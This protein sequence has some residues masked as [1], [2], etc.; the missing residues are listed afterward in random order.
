MQETD[1][2]LHGELA[3]GRPISAPLAWYPQ[4]VH[5]R[6]EE[7]AHFR[8]IGDGEGIHWPD[9]DEDISVEG[10]VENAAGH[11]SRAACGVE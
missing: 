11:A 4:L 3:D 10:I 6:A 9:F 7:R 2:S 5:A 8:L 1:D